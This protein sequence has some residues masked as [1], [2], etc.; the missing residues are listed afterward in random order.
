ML[1]LSCAWMLVSVTFSDE[2]TVNGIAMNNF[3]FQDVSPKGD[4]T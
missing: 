1:P 4:A 2:L 3:L